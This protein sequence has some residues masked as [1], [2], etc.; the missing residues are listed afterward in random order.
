[1]MFHHIQV[2]D[3]VTSD[4]STD[5]LSPDHP[6]WTRE[7]F[8]GFQNQVSQIPP[9]FPRPTEEEEENTTTYNEK[10][11][12]SDY[13]DESE[14]RARKRPHLD[15]EE[16][17]QQE[18]RSQRMIAPTRRYISEDDNGRYARGPSPIHSQTPH[19]TQSN[20]SR[21]TTST[22]PFSTTTNRY[23]TQTTPT[24]PRRP[25]LAPPR[26]TTPVQRQRNDFPEKFMKK[27][28]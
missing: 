17:P 24:N 27:P 12:D 11:E 23:S 18:R 4:D 5:T 9:G 28:R 6:R 13:V 19:R 22:S 1:M 10:E 3:L 14:L 16:V 8:F 7:T 26:S 15:Q 20:T 21:P 25:T 2:L